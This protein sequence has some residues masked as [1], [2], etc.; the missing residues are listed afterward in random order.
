M[1]TPI[2]DLWSPDPGDDYA[3]TQD[4]AAMADDI[5][6]AIL[7]NP[8]IVSV[9]NGTEQTAL[10]N[11]RILEGRPPT[12]QAPLFVLRRDYGSRLRLQYTTDGVSWTPVFGFPSRSSGSTTVPAGGIT[13][14]YPAGVFSG[15]PAVVAQPF[16]T[17]LVLVPH[18]TSFSTSGFLLRLF[19]LDGADVGGPAMWIIS[20]RG[21]I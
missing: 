11:Q 1:E 2:L 7:Q 13:V 4:L 12:E 9:A 3:L 20:A 17:G 15:L 18:I 16:N 5:E 14:T 19:T 8:Q 21:E 6:Q 10:V